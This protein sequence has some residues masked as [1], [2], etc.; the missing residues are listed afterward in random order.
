MDT[1]NEN[2]FQCLPSE[3]IFEI[4]SHLQPEER[5]LLSLVPFFKEILPKENISTYKTIL[6]YIKSN[7]VK[8]VNYLW[9]NK[10][11]WF[12]GIKVGRL[13]AK[14]NS[15][16]ILLWAIREIP[17][18]CD[19]KKILNYTAL[20]GDEVFLDYL[21][22]NHFNKYPGDN[23]LFVPMCPK[24]I[25]DYGIISGNILMYY[26]LKNVL[27]RNHKAKRK[28]V[29]I[30]IKHDFDEIFRVIFENYFTRKYNTVAISTFISDIFYKA[31]RHGAIEIAKYLYGEYK[32]RIFIV[33]QDLMFHAISSGKLNTVE[34]VLDYEEF[35]TLE[36]SFDTGSDAVKTG[37]I[38]IV[39]RV[40]GYLFADM[41]ENGDFLNL[42]TECM[43]SGNLDIIK[44][45]YLQF[46]E[47]FN[48]NANPPFNTGKLAVKYSTNTEILEF[49]E[50][51]GYI[52]YDIFLEDNEGNYEDIKNWCMDRGVV[53][54][55]ILL[56]KLLLGM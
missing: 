15:R 32:S 36:Y 45:I 16:D 41:A 29:K 7:N 42:V 49:L 35:P 28:H 26:Y 37:D 25:M 53:Y 27:T 40:F 47:E 11:S 17:S 52:F 6:F 39:K 30:C 55:N 31:I 18:T 9:I 33:G 34:F 8:I 14:Y 50:C 44:F 12:D 20:S 43:K 54:E 56:N 10:K 22:R 23:V 21:L 19:D 5:R 4:T 3:V 1:H 46:P 38:H 24:N 51:I 2:D 48:G 13:S